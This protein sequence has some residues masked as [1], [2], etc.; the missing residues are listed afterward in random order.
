MLGL[1]KVVVVMAVLAVVGGLAVHWAKDEASSAFHHAIDTAL[2][3]KVS[4]HPWA[5]VS[6]GRPVTAARVRFA[7]GQVT[8]VR[9]HASLG[10]YAA[11]INHEFSFQ[12][13]TTSVKAGCPGRKLASALRHASRVEVSTKS[14]VDTLTFTNDQRH[15]VATLQG[16]HR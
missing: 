7:D 9:C 10:T 5:P 15:T 1:L 12:K 4:A 8:S 6:H 14:G 13:A 2:P 16:R 11:S 3:D